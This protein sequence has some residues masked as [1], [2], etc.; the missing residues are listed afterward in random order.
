M[1]DSKF[2]LK[3]VMT[4]T[5]LL[6][7]LHSVDEGLNFTKSLLKETVLCDVMFHLEM[8]RKLRTSWTCK[9]GLSSGGVLPNTARPT[10]GYCAKLASD[11]KLEHRWEVKMFVAEF[12]STSPEKWRIIDAHLAGY[13]NTMS[14]RIANLCHHVKQ[15]EAKSQKAKWLMQLPW[16]SDPGAEIE[17]EPPTEAAAY[18]YGWDREFKKA[19]RVDQK[20]VVKEKREARQEGTF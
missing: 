11:V 8:R 19:W 14:C 10:S 3:G 12:S 9:V 18:V 1:N 7:T 5:P 6:V 17:V 20:L 4:A 16:H 2:D 15:A 13:V